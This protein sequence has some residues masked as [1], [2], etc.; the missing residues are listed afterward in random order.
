MDGIVGLGYE[1]SFGFGG[2]VVLRVR[3]HTGGNGINFHYFEVI[4]KWVPH[5]IVLVMVMEQ[6]GIVETDGGVHTVIATENIKSYCCCR[7]VNKP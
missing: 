5:P 6:M 2:L 1:S 4:M 3:S 7:S